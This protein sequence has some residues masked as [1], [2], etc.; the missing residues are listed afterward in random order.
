[1][2]AVM[3]HATKNSRLLHRYLHAISGRCVS[4]SIEYMTGMQDT[5]ALVIRYSPPG[6]LPAR[7]PNTAEINP[8]FRLALIPLHWDN[9]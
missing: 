2:H 4:S 3:H 9:L 5:M 6:L 8:F 7:P 1:M